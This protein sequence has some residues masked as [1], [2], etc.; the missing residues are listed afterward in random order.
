MQ[1]MSKIVITPFV[2][3]ENV[4]E[5][6]YTVSVHSVTKEQVLQI[7]FVKANEV[8]RGIEKILVT[9]EF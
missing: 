1:K 2:S 9:G 6:R 3:R 4:G 5:L 7:P 8:I